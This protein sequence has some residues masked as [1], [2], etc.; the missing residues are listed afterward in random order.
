MSFFGGG[1]ASIFPPSSWRLAQ[2]EQFRM[3]RSRELDA[4]VSPP[5]QE[6]K[7]ISI[8]IIMPL[9]PRACPFSV[10]GF[11]TTAAAIALQKRRQL[12][13][14][15]RLVH[16]RPVFQV[17]FALGA[18]G[19]GES[20]LVDCGAITVYRNSLTVCA[21]P[22][23]AFTTTRG[24]AQATWQQQDAVPLSCGPTTHWLSSTFHLSM[25]YC[26]P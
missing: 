19:V 14:M 2:E 26:I 8:I 10:A 6:S 1:L 23:A 9:Q 11:V 18:P 17:V 20:V 5:F 22:H 21:T 25:S 24:R 12:Q 16:P 13:E 3:Y 15:R 4:A 7:R